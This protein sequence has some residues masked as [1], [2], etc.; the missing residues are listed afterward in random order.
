MGVLAWESLT[1]R[2]LFARGNRVE[3]LRA[4]TQNPIPPPNA[5]NPAI[6]P[7]LNH[8]VARALARNPEE[9]F[10]SAREL[11]IALEEGV[12]SIGAP[13]STVAIAANIDR[14]FASE[15]EAQRS[16]ILK[17]R[18]DL[19]AAMEVDADE[20]EVPT[21]LF[22]GDADL[23]RLHQDSQQTVAGTARAKS[24]TAPATPLAK[25][26]GGGPQFARPPDTL[27]DVG[28]VPNL[29]DLNELDPIDDIPIDD[30]PIDDIPIDEEPAS[31][32]AVGSD[33]LAAMIDEV[34]SAAPP[35]GFVPLT[36]QP[37][38]SQVVDPTAT[39]Q[40]APRRRRT[41]LMLLLIL[42]LAGAGAAAGYVY[43]LDQQAL[44]K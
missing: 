29:E 7:P 19:E 36:D 21:R 32:H 5:L 37:A 4:I 30:I 13:L 41:W 31:L 1:G 34:A 39:S 8:V 26:K 17:A 6:P 43:W 11:G 15:L 16:I 35:S 42:I 9:R 23:D 14:Y 25:T 22:G 24:E 28:E 3:V 44:K 10:Q 40:V 18:R 20:F 2:R 33:N 27:S 12:S 38:A